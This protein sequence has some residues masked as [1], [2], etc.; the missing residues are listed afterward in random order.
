M[1]YLL[2]NTTKP[3]DKS[4]INEIQNQINTEIINSSLH[5]L[6]QLE[7]DA[8]YDKLNDNLYEIY[9]KRKMKYLKKDCCLSNL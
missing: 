2:F 5:K 3:N 1:K 6:Y 9:K 8:Y 7:R 4:I